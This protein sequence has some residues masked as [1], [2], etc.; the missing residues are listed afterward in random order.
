MAPVSREKAQEKLSFELPSQTY[1]LPAKE[2][3]ELQ[4]HSIHVEYAL[5][6][7][8]HISGWFDTFILKGI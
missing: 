5:M 8:K 2:S 4:G 6:A 1:C 7:F 3:L